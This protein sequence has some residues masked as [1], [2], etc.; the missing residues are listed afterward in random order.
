MQQTK[1]TESQVDVLMSDWLSNLRMGESGN[2]VHK[3]DRGIRTDSNM[4]Q[5]LIGNLKGYDYL[6]AI[7]RGRKAAETVASALCPTPVTVQT[8]GSAS[9]HSKE[10]GREVINLATDYFDDPNIGCDEKIDIML[11]LAAHEAAHS[12][13]T[14]DELKHRMLDSDKGSGTMKSLRHDIWNII[15]DERIEYHMGEDRPGMAQC[16]SAT[17]GYYF[18]KLVKRMKEGVGN[19]PTEPLPKLLA[20]ITQAVRYPSELTREQ[21]EENFDQ[22]DAVRRALTPYP[23]TSEAAWEAADRVME[24]I[25]DT[26]KQDLQ[27]KQ[28][29]QQQQ[30][31]DSADENSQSQGGQGQGQNGQQRQ[32]GQGS[33]ERDGQQ[34]EEQQR[35]DSGQGNGQGQQPEPTEQEIE[36]AI[37]EA[38]STKQGQNVM[39][40]ISED[41]RKADGNNSSQSLRDEGAKDFVNNDD[42]ERMSS[43]GAGGGNP[44]TFVRK[45]A[46]NPAVYHRHLKKVQKYVPAMARAL[47]CR[48]HQQDYTMPG[49]PKG[50]LDTTKFASYM[51]GETNI[52]IR[53]GSVKCSSAS[54]CILIDESGSMEGDLKIAAREA[55]ILVNEAVKRIPNV[56]FFCYGFTSK[57]LNVYSEDTKT[58]KWA[59]SVT[60]ATSG[61]PT[62]QAMDM[63]TRRIRKRTGDP[64]LMLVLTDGVPDNSAACIRM[65]KEIRK[66]GVI[67]I[68]V[69]ILTNA[70]E[71][72]FS[73]SIVMN[74][75]S[76]LSVKIGRITK[77]KLE[78][79]L[80]RT[81]ENS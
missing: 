69:G 74:D 58:S 1:P 78:T 9:S 61:T 26:A 4:R 33:E 56:R 81:D 17:K 72:T 5:Y 13:Y 44:D 47:T 35:Q 18:K 12:A 3:G 34:Q 2:Y 67:P 50:K 7:K 15:E 22:L 19:M 29:Q 10:N 41:E 80:V 48:S 30:D 11:G 39:S 52:F 25:K 57:K 6:E 55:S 63:C 46:G 71:K 70:V 31:R 43:S 37:E 49:Q 36:K 65:D 73:E 42:S 54:V 62:A 79:M 77:G 24:I 45:P 66:K 8:G 21:A 23:L 59:L 64:V 28:Q 68:G 20:A 60:E 14:D 76:D 32:D 27:Q 16:L 38:L 40:A 53:Y 75:I 51:A